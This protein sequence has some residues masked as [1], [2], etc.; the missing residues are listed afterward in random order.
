MDPDL[1]KGLQQI[2]K[3]LE[4]IFSQQDFDKQKS[5]LLDA[6]PVSRPG[7]DLGGV[8]HSPTSQPQA[9]QPLKGVSDAESRDPITGRHLWG[10]HKYCKCPL[11]ECY[12]TDQG[13]SP[14][15]YLERNASI[16]LCLLHD[17]SQGPGTPVS[18]T[19][20]T[21]KVR[22]QLISPQA[23]I[24]IPTEPAGMID[25]RGGGWEDWFQTSRLSYSY[26]TCRND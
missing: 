14:A 25:L 15:M 4:G 16:R 1:V 18:F 22:R 7:P 11:L 5:A 17:G 9:S 19:T 21:P 13:F 8:P 10:Y 23:A 20:P 2:K 26:Y 24:D 6:Y 3:F 12:W